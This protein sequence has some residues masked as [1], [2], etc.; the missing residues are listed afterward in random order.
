MFHFAAVFCLCPEG[1]NFI[2]S[3][4][5]LLMT[6]LIIFSQTDYLPSTV[7]LCWKASSGWSPSVQP[8]AMVV[9]HQGSLSSG[10][11]SI[12]WSLLS[13]A[14]HHGGI[15]SRQSFIW[16]SFNSVVSPQ[17]GLSSFWSFLSAVFHQGGLSSGWYFIRWSFISGV[18]HQV[19]FPQCGLSSV[20]S[21]TSAVFHQCSLL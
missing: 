11:L 20:W 14:F 15:T 18:F 4:T 21:F 1:S 8:F 9:L 10:G 6:S 5:V 7:P 3:Q 17:C 19:V 16:W 12:A 13:A 2:E